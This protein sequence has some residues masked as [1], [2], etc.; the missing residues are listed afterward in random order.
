MTLLHMYV[1]KQSETFTGR[2]MGPFLPLQCHTW[3]LSAGL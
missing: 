2:K 3:L 1:Y